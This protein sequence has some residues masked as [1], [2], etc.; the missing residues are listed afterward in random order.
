VRSVAHSIRDS[1]DFAPNERTGDCGHGDHRV[2]RNAMVCATFL[3]GQVL[4]P[5][6]DNR[7]R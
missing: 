1:A 5:L 3:H 2:H 4:G 7:C 6:S